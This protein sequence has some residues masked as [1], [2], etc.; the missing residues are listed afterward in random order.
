M[1]NEDKKIGYLDKYLREF[2]EVTEPYQYDSRFIPT[3]TAIPMSNEDN[4]CVIQSVDYGWYNPVNEIQPFKA[5]PVSFSQEY[6][7][8]TYTDSLRR[9]LSPKID[10]RDEEIKRLKDENE[11]L[12]KA[13]EDEYE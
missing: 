4:N 6:Y 3:P 7:G 12:R 10:P 9:E 13:L 8:K 2:A 5:S 1:S 11:M